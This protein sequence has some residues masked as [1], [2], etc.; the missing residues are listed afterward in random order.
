MITIKNLSFAYD[1]NTVIRNFSE[2]F[3]KGERVCIKGESGKG[4]TTLLRLIC[5]LEKPESDIMKRKPRSKNDGIFAGGL[6]IDCLYQGVL[7]T[8]LTVA[9]FYIGEFLE[10]GTWIFRNISDC[11]EGMTMAFFTIIPIK[12]IIP[13]M[14]MKVKGWPKPNSEGVMP[15]KTKGK[16]TKISNTFF[17]L[18]NSNSR[19]PKIMNSMMG[20]YFIKLL[21]ASPCTSISPTQRLW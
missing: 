5:G 17:Q 11:N 14:A 6:G 4:K 13:I 15:Q 16:Q 20:R 8:V 12:P 18:L 9:A 21:I 1:E 19:T 10:T 7:V 2:C 3:K